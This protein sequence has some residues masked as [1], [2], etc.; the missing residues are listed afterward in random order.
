[1]NIMILKKLKGQKIL[2]FN[3]YKN[4]LFKNEIILNSQQT[5]KSEE[6]F[7]HTGEINNIALSSN[8]DKRWKIFDR[9]RTY[10][11]E[12]NPKYLKVRC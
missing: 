1:M 2:R 8:E 4:C 5:F 12:T 9:I 10:P 6:Q 11:Y 3:D 7:V